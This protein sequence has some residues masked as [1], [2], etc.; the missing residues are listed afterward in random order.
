MVKCAKVL[1]YNA[2]PRDSFGKDV[3]AA[4]ALSLG[5]PVVFF[6][7]TETRHRFYRDVHPLSRLINF[8]N[9]VSVGAIVTDNR[10]HVVE[11]LSRIFRNG[12]ELELKKKKNNYFLL[13]DKLT[14][15]TLRL[16]TDDLLLRETFWNY[17]NE[18]QTY[19]YP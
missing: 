11:S 13:V 7:D 2:G 18:R 4:M 6:C 3:E 15:S 16:Q 12:M 14:D 19:L 5:K 8:Q 10:L 9:G 17:Y 1:V